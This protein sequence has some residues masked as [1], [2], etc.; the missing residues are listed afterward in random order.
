MRED[1][2]ELAKRERGTLA[3]DPMG[4]AEGVDAS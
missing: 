4:F 3:G 2:I 1:V